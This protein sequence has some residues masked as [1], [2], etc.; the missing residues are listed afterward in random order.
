[1]KNTESIANFY[2]QQFGWIPKGLELEHAHF[3]VFDISSL[4]DK[5]LST[6]PFKRRDFYKITLLY[7]KDVVLNYADKTVEID[8]HA[9]VFSNPLI[10]YGWEGLEHVETGHYCIFQS[11][12]FPPLWTIV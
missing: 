6:T 7:G 4:I 8:G 3:N 12:I 9:L 1:M 11:S 2:Q 5:E 10:P